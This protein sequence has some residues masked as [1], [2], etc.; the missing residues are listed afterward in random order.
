MNDA[1]INMEMPS[2]DLNTINKFNAVV[3]IPAVDRD[4]RIGSVFNH[5]FSVIYQTEN[6]DNS[7]GH[8][9]IHLLSVLTS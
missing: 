6:T 1:L 7:S 8:S 9:V 5:I 2:V 3:K 4:A